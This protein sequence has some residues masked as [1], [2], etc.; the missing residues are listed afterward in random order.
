MKLSE[1]Q[2]MVDAHTRSALAQDL[3]LRTEDQERIL[4]VLVEWIRSHASVPVSDPRQVRLLTELPRFVAG[5]SFELDPEEG[6]RP[7]A[8]SGDSIALLL[9]RG[10]VWLRGGN[11][12]LAVA[13]CVSSETRPTP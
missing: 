3:Q 10:S 8:R 4:P 6:L 2:A 13:A 11:W 12:Q 7:R 9:E 5:L 1:A